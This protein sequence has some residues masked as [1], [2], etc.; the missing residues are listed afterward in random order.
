MNVWA[1]AL[2]AARVIVR[3][4]GESVAFSCGSDTIARGRKPA[5]T[6]AVI[7]REIRANSWPPFFFKVL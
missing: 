3:A 7:F 5:H 2:C 1:A 6:F 4:E